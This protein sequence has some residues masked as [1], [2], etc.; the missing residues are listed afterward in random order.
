MDAETVR[1]KISPSASSSERT[2]EG[3]RAP[4][5]RSSLVQ[6]APLRNERAAP[7]RPREA[8]HAGEA[9]M[10]HP[11]NTIVRPAPAAK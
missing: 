6:C 4:S 5:Q 3:A 10:G 9:L 7:E 11:A 1:S 2:F 8:R